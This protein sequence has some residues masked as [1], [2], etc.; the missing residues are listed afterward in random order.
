MQLYKLQRKQFD[1]ITLKEMLKG[2]NCSLQHH[3]DQHFTDTLHT[4]NKLTRYD[5]NRMIVLSQPFFIHSLA[6]GKAR[7]IAR[8]RPTLI[9]S[10]KLSIIRD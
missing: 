1:R 10:T 6:N 5:I 3:K 9:G 4:A 2:T 8:R 7:K